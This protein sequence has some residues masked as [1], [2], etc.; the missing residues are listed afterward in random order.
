MVFKCIKLLDKGSELLWIKQ[1]KC[2]LPCIFQFRGRGEPLLF[3]GYRLGFTRIWFGDNGQRDVRKNANEVHDD[4]CF[5][6]EGNF[7]RSLVNLFGEVVLRKCTFKVEVFSR[8]SLGCLS[9]FSRQNKARYKRRKRNGNLN[10]THFFSLGVLFLFYV[11][12]FSSEWGLFGRNTRSAI[13][14]TSS[15]LVCPWSLTWRL[16]RDENLNKQP[17]WYISKY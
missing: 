11:L 12:R 17:L 8:S 10:K 16:Q 9:V 5:R 15:S 6:K 4:N 3:R 1:E 2:T 7:F 13:R 14:G